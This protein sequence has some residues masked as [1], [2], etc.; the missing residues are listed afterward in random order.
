MA[1]EGHFDSYPGGAPLI[2]IGHPDS[3]AERTRVLLEIPKLSSL[4]LRHD[5]NAPLPGLKTFPKDERP[6]AEIVFW[7]FRIMVGIGMLILALGLWSLLARLRAGLYDWRLLHRFALVMGPAGF[8]AVIAGWVTTEVGRQPWVIYGLMRTRD[9][10]S[11]IAAPAVGASL[12]AFVIVYFAV[13][14]AGTI[15][16]LKLMALAPAAGERGEP[17]API[18]TA[19]ITPS[20]A[21]RGTAPEQ[22]TE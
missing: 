10:V 7:S 5:A 15:Y 2:L 6:P 12:L 18:R 22:E 3:Q 4:I 11:P 21:L 17:H 8:V 14:A 16:I 20:P 9:A 13:F 1:M 19:G